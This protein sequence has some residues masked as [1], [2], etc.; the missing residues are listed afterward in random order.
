M[1]IELFIR[2]AQRGDSL[3][4]IADLNVGETQFV[5]GDRLNA[6]IPLCCKEG[7]DSCPHVP[8]KQRRAK[9]NVGL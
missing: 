1:D 6:M 7:W 5:E 8:K 2:E 3:K 9:K 4:P